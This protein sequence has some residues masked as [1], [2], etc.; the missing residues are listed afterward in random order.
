MHRSNI[1]LWLAVATLGFAALISAQG[2]PKKQKPAAKDPPD[3]IEVY[4]QIPVPSGSVRR[5]ITTRH[6]SSYYLYAELTDGKTVMLI[7]LTKAKKPTVLADVAYP[8]DSGSMFAVAGTSALVTEEVVVPATP[9]VPRTLRIMDFSDPTHPTVTKEFTGITA[10]SRDE[11]GG[12]IFLGDAHNIWILH[13][14]LAEDPEV[15]R[16]YA[17]KILYQ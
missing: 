16:E 1:G 14:T 15:E 6:Y 3:Q 12:L 2:K 7:D 9:S 4:A 5:F 17:R 11:H 10:M 13:Q 8:S